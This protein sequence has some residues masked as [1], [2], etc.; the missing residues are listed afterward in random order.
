MTT[1]TKTALILGITGGFGRETAVALARQGWRIRALHRDPEAAADR[2][3]EFA[4]IDW[5]MGDAMSARD[6]AKAA[7]G[8]DAIVHGVNPPGYRNWR[9]LALPMLENS[10]AAAKQGGAR[11]LFPGNVYNYGPVAMPVA[12]E[13]SPQDP[14][15]RKGRIRV[16]M[17]KRLNA[18]ANE[19][20]KVLILR[21]G[22]YF[23]PHAPGSWLSNA[24]VKPGKPVTSVVYPG[25]P[26]AG[27]AWA[28]LPD[29]AETAARLLAREE[30]LPP[31]E[32]FHFGGHY[33]PRGGAMAE[34]ILRAA[35]NP[36][37]K[38]KPLPWWAVRLTAPVNETFRELLEM[39]YLW[40]V[41][42]KLEDARLRRF[43]GEV[44]HTPLDA[45]VR[46][47]LDGLGS[48]P[49]EKTPQPMRIVA[50]AQPDECCPQAA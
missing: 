7:Q 1:E 28:Y 35:G 11:I 2:F 46:E 31:F 13:D 37:G 23:G 18:A 22:D 29:L 16:E 49:A 39:R 30:D 40:R 4:D 47:T 21:A 36:E 42:L 33:L 34:A 24:M 27:H 5:R 25:D 10:I 12:R 6:V 15:T 14:F 3:P 32:R 45:A 20:A 9:G 44:P 48:L 41:D 50:A 26:D 43:L 8:A 19:G 17:E 38:I